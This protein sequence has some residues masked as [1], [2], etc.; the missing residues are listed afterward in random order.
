[1]PN[2]NT[3]LGFHYFPDTLH[4]RETDSQ[5]WIPELRALG[6]SW[7]VLMAPTDR[8]IPEAFIRHLV[9][10]GIQPV[11]H[12]I[13]S[14]SKP[15]KPEDLKTLLE[16]YAKWGVIYTIFFD[17]PNH[18]TAW[19]AHN[20]TQEDLV[21]RFL[22]RF[23]PLASQSLQC[24]LVPVLPPLQPGGSYW[25]TAF[26]RT[27]L[28]ALER[29]KQDHLLDRLALSAYGWSS[30]KSLNWGSGGPERWPGARPYLTPSGEEDQIGFRA[31]DWYLAIGQ[32]QL[33]HTIPI[34]ILGGGILEDPLTTPVTAFDRVMHAKINLSLAQVLNGETVADPDDPARMLDKVSAN[35][36]C[37]NFWLMTTTPESPYISQAWFQPEG[38]SLPV[39]GAL[40]QWVAERENRKSAILN[41]ENF[42]VPHPI[43]HYLLIPAYEWGVADWHLDVIRPFVKKYHPTI[44]FSLQ[45]A[46][47]AERVTVI[48]SDNIF[49]ENDLDRLRKTG[50]QVERIQGDG[51]SI[52]T[53]LAER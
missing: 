26:I 51:T 35:V 19:D 11:L 15:P 9:S 24:G 20:W 43:A 12:F 18:H 7:L 48:G 36:L 1:M 5:T 10:A 33:K 22:D 46:F 23:I 4:Y 50:C 42:A 6:A 16:T 53:Q 13:P 21:E 38:Q 37:C 52:A 45:E 2:T 27:S 39:V 47:F 41:P 8:A 32:S 29:R 14:L 34:L 30:H 17:R 31:Y 25:D 44:G 3:R 40:K 28:Q 49:S